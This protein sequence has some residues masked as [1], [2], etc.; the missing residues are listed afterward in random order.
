M[1]R[2]RLGIILERTEASP[3]ESQRFRQ[4]L[5]RAMDGD[6]D[7]AAELTGGPS[8]PIPAPLNPKRGTAQIMKFLRKY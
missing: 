5:S 3:M 7:A 6:E 2:P 1:N 4:L 8:A